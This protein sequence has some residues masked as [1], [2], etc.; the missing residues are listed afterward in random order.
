M[1]TVA[2]NSGSAPAWVWRFVFCL[3]GGAAYAGAVIYLGGLFENSNAWLAGCGLVLWVACAWMAWR[4]AP[5]A[6]L[7]AAVT[8][9]VWGG[10]AG[11]LASVRLM[12]GELPVNWSKLVIAAVV[13]P[14]LILLTVLPFWFMARK[15]DSVPGK[16]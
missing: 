1:Q 11:F 12:G 2:K 5:V 10:V 7:S 4:R 3:L 8:G 9:L 14:L 16:N 15:P 6:E 13:I